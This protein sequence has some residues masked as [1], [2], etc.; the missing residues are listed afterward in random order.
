[1]RKFGPKNKGHNYPRET[2][3]NHFKRRQHHLFPRSAAPVS[4]RY[5]FDS[6]GSGGIADP[7][8]FQVVFRWFVVGN[9]LLQIARGLV[10]TIFFVH[11]VALKDGVDDHVY[12]HAFRQ[13]YHATYRVTTWPFH[14]HL[15]FHS[16]HP[17][18]RGRHTRCQR[19]GR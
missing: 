2:T 18:R 1:M 8:P 14:S 15:L 16:A 5:P 17:K 10:G 7:Q 9:G 4:S 3:S 12:R 6:L 19:P 13:S 11:T